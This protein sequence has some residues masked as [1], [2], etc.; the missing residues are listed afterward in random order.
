MAPMT[1]FEK[2]AAGAAWQKSR[3]IPGDASGS[4]P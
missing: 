3:F 2:T 1:I 4:I